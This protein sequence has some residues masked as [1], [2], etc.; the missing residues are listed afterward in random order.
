LEYVTGREN[1]SRAKRRKRK[2]PTG[3]HPHKGRFRA[4]ICKN[5]KTYHLGTFDAI[6]GASNAYQVALT[7]IENV[8]KY[9]V[10]HKV[11]IYGFGVKK[12]KGRFQA[13]I[14]IKGKNR[15]F[16]CY[17]TAEEASKVATEARR[18]LQAGLLDLSQYS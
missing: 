11:S 10:S 12:S 9:L 4:T 6:T 16:G 1:I 14:K 5:G 17:S 8:E 3:V 2:L 13:R 7:D 15:S 18:K